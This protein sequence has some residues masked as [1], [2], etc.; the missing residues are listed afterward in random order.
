[1]SGGG[2]DESEAVDTGAV[3]VSVVAVMDNED[4]GPPLLP[5]ELINATLPP[6]LIPMLTITNAPV[7]T[8]TRRQYNRDNN[9]CMIYL[10]DD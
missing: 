7:A 1:V 6:L 5:D 3:D 4:V 9:D 8:N 10:W 2:T